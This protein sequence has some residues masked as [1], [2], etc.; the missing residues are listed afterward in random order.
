MYSI[1]S[2][3]KWQEDS[4]VLIG[5]TNYE[6]VFSSDSFIQ[7]RDFVWSA[8]SFRI[9]EERR[10]QFYI[11]KKLLVNFQSSSILLRVGVE[12]EQ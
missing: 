2:P 1:K 8:W 3:E 11:V 7:N 10:L 5:S 9:R 12:V 6:Y 4:L